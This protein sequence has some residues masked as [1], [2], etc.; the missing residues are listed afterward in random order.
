M[1]IRAPLQPT[2][3][4]LE[5]SEWGVKVTMSRWREWYRGFIIQTTANIK[6]VPDIQ[7]LSQGNGG[8]GQKIH[9][10][11]TVYN[12]F[13]NQIKSWSQKKVKNQSTSED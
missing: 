5:Q 12:F 10:S 6:K 8:G 13:S 9:M 7:R 11:H 2:D 4:R 3:N 1:E